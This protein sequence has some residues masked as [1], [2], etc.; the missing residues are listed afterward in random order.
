MD[1]ELAGIVGEAWLQ[2]VNILADRKNVTQ[3]VTIMITKN[4][5]KFKKSNKNSQT[6]TLSGMV[7]KKIQSTDSSLTSNISSCHQSVAPT[8]THE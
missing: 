8:P 5:H 2:P 6:K 7:S 3:D 4:A 1:F